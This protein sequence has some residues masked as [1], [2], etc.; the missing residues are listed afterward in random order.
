M[1]ISLL[2]QTWCVVLSKIWCG[3]LLTRAGQL[4]AEYPDYDIRPPPPKDRRETESAG[5]LTPSTPASIATQDSDNVSISDQSAPVILSRERNRLTLRAY[6]RHLLSNQDIANS[7]IT[8][9]F[10]L[11]EPI[12]L[13]NEERTD[14]MRREEMDRM[15]EA[16]ADK[17]KSE[18]SGRVRELESYLR[19]FKDELV[20]KDGLTR[21]FS[22]IRTTPKLQDLPIEYQKV[23]EWARISLAST[24][25]QLF[26]G[27]DQSS[28]IFA[29][30]KRVH[31]MMPYFM[32]RQILKISNP[33]AMIRSAM[34]LFLARPFGAASLLQRIFSGG[35][36]S[37]VKEL[38]DDMHKVEEKVEDPILCERVKRY[39]SSSRAIQQRYRK[40]AQQE[41]LDILTIM[42]RSRDEGFPSL[43]PQSLQRVH[44]ASIKFKEYQDWVATLANPEEEDEGPEDDDAWLFEDLHVLMRMAMRLRDKEQLLELIFEVC[45]LWLVGVQN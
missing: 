35:I 36:D 23:M 25:Y 17:F 22:T 24:I 11:H 1:A 19:G 21:V 38:R 41:N 29:Q 8:Q 6:L 40:E 12:E 3:L 34:D 30:F 2:Y 37:E 13:S 42:M 31:G 20:K 18:V 26:L 10:L 15:R 39:V 9:N 32:M 5:T 27:S 16:E 4:R 14:A 28:A 7:G 45:T 43:S 33:V 44:R